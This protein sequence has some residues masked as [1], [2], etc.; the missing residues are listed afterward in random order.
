MIKSISDVQ[1]GFI[2]VFNEGTNIS[3]NITI[4]DCFIYDGQFK[5]PPVTASLDVKPENQFAFTELDNVLIPPVK[6]DQLTEGWWDLGVIRWNHGIS[7]LR[8]L[9]NTHGTSLYPQQYILEVAVCGYEST[10]FSTYLTAKVISGPF[11]SLPDNKAVFTKFRL[12]QS[13]S[14]SAGYLCI[15]GYHTG[16]SLIPKVSIVIDSKSTTDY[17]YFNGNSWITTIKPSTTD[18]A[19]GT[20]EVIPT[21]EYIT[22]A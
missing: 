7:Y 10:L 9:I 22:H 4:S 11:A 8:F 5:N 13:R 17:K 2:I 21:I 14:D 1:P 19:T 3:F 20:S 15:Q 16:T 12:G 18:I 6:Y